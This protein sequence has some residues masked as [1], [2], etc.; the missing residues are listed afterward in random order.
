MA[1][2]VIFSA[3]GSHGTVFDT[4]SVV[5]SSSRSTA[6]QSVIGGHTVSVADITVQNPAEVAQVEE[7]LQPGKPAGY[8]QKLRGFLPDLSNFLP[9]IRDRLSRFTVTSEAVATPVFKPTR[10]TV[11]HKPGG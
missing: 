7:V 4:A 2:P 5:S 10:V 3:T 6:S 8:M 1:N 9:Q 11:Y